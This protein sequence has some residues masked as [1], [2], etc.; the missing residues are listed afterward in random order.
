MIKK[1]LLAGLFIF[2][3][4][5]LFA[6]K[7]KVKGTLSFADTVSKLYLYY[8]KDN[9]ERVRDSAIIKD[10]KFEF[11]GELS[12]PVIANLWISFMKKE[13]RQRKAEK[14]QFYL[15]KGVTKIDIKDSATKAIIRGSKSQN[16]FA[17]IN[18]LLRPYELEN[19]SLRKQFAVSRKAKDSA[20]MEE[21]TR[22]VVNNNRKIKDTR[23]AFILDHPKSFVSFK[24]LQDYTGVVIDSDVAEPLF[25]VLA[26]NIRTSEFGK[27]FYE[28]IQK[29]KVTALGKLAMDF[30]QNDTLGKPVSLSDFRGKYVLLDFWASWCGPCRAE[31]PNVVKAHDKYKDKNFTVLGV[32]LDQPGAKQAWMDAIHKDQ[33]WWTHVS[34]LKYWDN[35][36]AK[37]YRIRAIPQ[38]LLIDPNGNIVAKNIRGEEL[39][40]KL[41]E[42]FD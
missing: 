5:G 1:S 19:D 27:K 6:Q 25:N 18:A 32:S 15:E 21:I 11:S 42:I 22:Q 13:G 35:A 40:N 39:Q 4:A 17:L 12:I 16:E 29:S 41:A 24:V 30:T 20:K 36:V 8:D 26:E 7:A 10:G 31:N 9:G 34:D 14:V 3:S 33:L 23:R 28:E 37:Q 2:V 38:N